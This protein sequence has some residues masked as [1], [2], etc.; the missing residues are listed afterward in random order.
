M[1]SHKHEIEM[2]N[3]EDESFPTTIIFYCYKSENLIAISIKHE[4]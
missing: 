3:E 1:F 2:N 4:D